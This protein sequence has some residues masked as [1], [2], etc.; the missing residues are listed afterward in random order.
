MIDVLSPLRPLLSAIGRQRLMPLLI[1][2]QVA[3]ACA[4]LTNALFLLASDV[5]VACTC[6]LWGV[7]NDA[8]RFWAAIAGAMAC[9]AVAYALAWAVYPPWAK[10]PAS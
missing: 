1:A 9:M 6:V 5:G 2:A 4:I 7:V 10:R 3:L 8:F